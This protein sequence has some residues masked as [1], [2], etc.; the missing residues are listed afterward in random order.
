MSK[1]YDIKRVVI[2]VRGGVAYADDV[3]EGVEVEIIDHDNEGREEEEER[4]I[5]H[6][7]KRY[8]GT[9]W[10]TGDLEESLKGYYGEDFEIS[11]DQLSEIMEK[12]E[13]R[14]LEDV[15]ERGNDTMQS[16]AI[17][18]IEETK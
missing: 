10:T 13:G 5:T 2:H 1:S 15:C 16:M 4:T 3:P 17:R 6:N 9:Y 18:I 8:A 12:I 14:L 11:D 7:E